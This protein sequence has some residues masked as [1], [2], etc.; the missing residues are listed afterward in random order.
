MPEDFGKLDGLREI[1]APAVPAQEY[2]LPWLLV[3]VCVLVVLS[4]LVLYARYRQRP[5]TRARRY[6]RKL[7]GAAM[8]MNPARYGDAITEILRIYSGS[9]DLRSATIST[10]ERREW[11]ALIDDCNNLRFSGVD[12][13]ADI[14]ART[15]ARTEKLLWPMR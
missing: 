10:L 13:C 5:L 9:Q 4:C 8:R 7:D 1:I 11:L 14:V 6:F 2:Q 3:L 15:I 12:S